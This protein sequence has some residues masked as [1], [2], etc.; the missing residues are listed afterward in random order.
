M[1]LPFTIYDLRFTIWKKSGGAGSP[2]PA[3]DAQPRRARSDAPYLPQRGLQPSVFCPS[4]PVRGIGNPQSQRGV[5][6]II[7][8]ILL[9]VVTFM[10]VAFLAL[11][12]RERGAVTTVTDTAGARLAA[13]AALANAEAQIVANALAITNP[14]SFGLLVST[15]YINPNG[16]VSGNANFYNV[17]YQYP[18]GGSLSTADFLQNLA[19]L[20]YS[21]RPPVFIP[22]NSLGSNDF[23]YYLDLN[24]NGRYDTNGWV[25]NVDNNGLGLGTTNFQVGDPEWIGVLQRPDQPYGPNNPFIARYA[26]I[27]VPVGNTL[28]LNA[29]HNQVF[30]E[31]PARSSTTIPVYSSPET[32]DYY[33]RNQGVGSWEI[34]LA[35]FFADLNTN[36]WLPTAPPNNTYYYYQYLTRENQGLAFDDARALL[37]WRYN[38]NYNTLASVDNLFGGTLSA[39]HFAFVNDGIDGYSDGPLQITLDTNADYFAADTPSSPWAGADNTNHFYTHQELF[40]SNEISPLFVNRLLAAGTNVSTYD[41]YTYYRLLSQLGTDTTPD[42]GKMNLNYDNLTPTNGVAAS[43]NFMP[44]TPLAFFTNAADRLLRA[45]TTQWRNGNPTNFATT[46]YAATGFT[47]MIASQ[48]TNNYLAFGITNIPVLISNQ[49]VYSSAVNRLLQLAANLYDATTN[50]ASVMGLNYPSVFRPT[51]WVTNEFGY[52]NVYINGY[53]DVSAYSQLYGLTVGVP[54][55]DTPTNATALPYGIVS[56]LNQ[57]LRNVYGVPWIIGAKKG[58]PNFN[59]FSLQDVVQITRKLEVS[60]KEVPVKQLSDLTRTNQMIVFSISNSIGMDLWNSYS[61]WYPRAVQ[62]VVNDNLVMKMSYDYPSAGQFYG[63][64][65]YPAYTN[66]T[67]SPNTTWSGSAWTTTSLTNAAQSSFTIPINNNLQFMPSNV[68]YYGTTPPGPQCIGFQPLALNLGWESNNY[69]LA[70]TNNFVLAMTNRLQVFMLDGNHII[71]YAQFAGPNSSRNLT[72]EFQTNYGNTAY[73]STPYDGIWNTNLYNNDH[74]LNLPLGIVNQFAISLGKGKL[75]LPNIYWNDPEA[76]DAIA[77]FEFFMGQTSSI[78]LKNQTQSYYTN[79][80]VQLPYNPTVSA[81][82]YV[83]WQANDPLVHYLASDLTFQGTENG[84]SGPKTGITATALAQS[85]PRPSFTQ[86]NDRY[87]PWGMLYT[88]NLNISPNFLDAN[89]WNL[90]YKDPLVRI[91][92]NWDFPANKLPTVGWI[93]R[94]HRGT[95]WQTI[96]LKASDVLTDFTMFVGSPLPIGTNTWVNWT[97]DSQLTYGQYFD[98]ANSAPVRDHLLFDLFTTA[99]NDNATR[100]TLSVNQNHLAAWSAVFS[101]VTVL[102]NNASDV[103]V[104]FSGATPQ[105]QNP[106][107][108]YSATNIIQPAG[109]AGASSPLGQLVNGINQTRATFTNTDGQVG[110]FEHL[111]DI[112][113]VEQLTEQSPFLKAVTNGV[114]DLAQQKNGISDEMYE[115]LPQQTMSLL[116]D[117]GS[118]RYVIY[119][120]GQT[121]KPAP[122][123]VINSS[124]VLPSGL[125]PF[126]MITNYQ[127][128]SEIA[129]RA[130][131]RFNSTLTNVITSTNDGSGN[132]IWYS[133]PVVT[134]NNAVIESFNILPPD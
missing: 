44:W 91:S 59:K 126:G 54:P 110:M 71:D 37:A 72:A 29:I 130:V 63:P 65:N 30:V 17:N 82:E 117:S 10:A 108:R 73:F 25:T 97:G 70:F 80:T 98:A 128:V 122:D 118:P 5:A 68:F 19:N 74:N 92:D 106:P 119:C 124:S 105:F 93:G 66:E 24:R 104:G 113:S 77:G 12:R 64:S 28:D 112:L 89:A 7:T 26:F 107:P 4:S 32:A 84:G 8:L 109:L 49:F 45:Y 90:A 46:Y 103:S 55:L 13:D 121:L 87:Q 52:K 21:P 102:S 47:N 16:F 131:V 75:A 100:G 116:R 132:I 129:T 57:T 120:Y 125:N 123:S 48:W 114:A 101:G 88:N 3:A 76:S 94:V 27:A 2:L 81:Y 99:F 31:P 43:T 1:K 111:G 36:Q 9:G 15:N 22:T 134:N 79:T 58:F 50:N 23:R 95:P 39:G 11:S 34:N 69:S 14:Y 20:Y 53:E 61:S 133:Q 62:I 86:V 38:N 96:Y 127:V 33:F 51:F 83:S 85:V 78:N 115:W 56:G 67:I 41:R 35:A 18:G 6:L 42:S 40:Y 60:S